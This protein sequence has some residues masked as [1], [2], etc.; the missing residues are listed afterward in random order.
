MKSLLFFLIFSSVVF[1]Q[2]QKERD[3]II[4]QSNPQEVAA[5]KEILKENYFK[6]QIKYYAF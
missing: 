2:T 4:K 3:F 1:S 6:N 5:L